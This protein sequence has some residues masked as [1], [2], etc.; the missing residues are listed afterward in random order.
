MAGFAHI[1]L[2][3]YVEAVEWLRKA[4]RHPNSAFWTNLNLAVVFVEQEEWDKA[5]AAIDA[6]LQMQPDLSVTAVAAMLGSLHPDWKD[7]HL[8]DLR[9]AGLPE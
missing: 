8:D 5:R 6:A 3:E 2:G 7:R 9:K 4:A 1:H